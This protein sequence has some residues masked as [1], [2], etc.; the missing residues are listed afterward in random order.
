MPTP[1]ALSSVG[2]LALSFALLACTADPEPTASPA[3]PPSATPTS[4]RTQPAGSPT[5]AGAGADPENC[6]GEIGATTVETVIVPA[7]A[8]CT[9]AGTQVEGNVLVSRDAT[10][11]ADGI[12]VD[13]N[14]RAECA[15][16][17]TER[18][19]GRGFRPGRRA[20]R[21]SVWVR[22]YVAASRS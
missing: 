21:R 5:D 12:R 7:G 6:D 11:V 10:L 13:G 16:G 15:G 3:G 18:E 19:N 1:R 20:C 22:L 14:I 8:S 9:L 4:A 17:R 2:G